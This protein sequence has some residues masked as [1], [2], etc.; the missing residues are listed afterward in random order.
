[1]READ[2]GSQSADTIKL[3]FSSRC[4]P[5]GGMSRWAD[6]SCARGKVELIY[7]G[8]SVLG[9]DISQDLSITWM[10]ELIAM[11]AYIDEGQRRLFEGYMEKDALDR[12]S[13]IKS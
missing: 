7:R 9:L 1:M 8:Y 4:G 5:R 10:K 3:S 13:R 2:V 11:A 12:A 6:D